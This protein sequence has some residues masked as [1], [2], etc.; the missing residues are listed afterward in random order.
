MANVDI[1]VIIPSK[2]NK[3][4]TAEVIRRIAEELKELEVEF[5]IIDM[6]STDNSVLSTLNEIKERNL[7]GYV[8]QSG[9]STVSSALNTGIYKSDGKYITF[10]YPS[11]LYKGG[12]LKDYCKVTE[13]KNSDIVFS[14][15]SA[16]KKKYKIV[17][18]EL[19]NIEGTDL[20][21]GLMRSLISIDFCA[22]MIKREYLLSNH[23]KFYEECT[24]GYAEA[25]VFNLLLFN[26]KISY[27]DIK[28]ER[29]YT[30]SKAKEENV[31]NN[32]CFARVEALLK[33]Y[34]TIGLTHKENTLLNDIFEY[35]KL[36]SAVMSS[37]DMLLKEGFQHSAVKN[38]LKLKHYD[39]LL[40]IS[41]ITPRRLRLKIVKWK[42]LPK[43]YKP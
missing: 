16:E 1:S 36:P 27:A 19:E 25:F 14:I 39:R 10:V 9:G 35:D 23:I 33:V 20:A 31:T 13:E 6:N 30:N 43:F 15:P 41:A 22:V 17:E 38:S 29:D 24:F 28:L 2:N 32:H 34:E 40:K 21:I 11:R 8:I 42:I 26:P 18:T 4:R 37:I 12:Y 7:R 5:I 3:N